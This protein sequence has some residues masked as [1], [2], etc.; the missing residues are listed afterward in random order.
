MPFLVEGDDFALNLTYFP[1]RPFGWGYWKSALVVAVDP[2]PGRVVMV[3][4]GLA[5]FGV[6]VLATAAVL[7]RRGL[8]SL[9]AGCG[10]RGVGYSWRFSLVS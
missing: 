8:L 1:I 6:C 2:L 9:V 3:L 4:C 5:A 10:P 7:G